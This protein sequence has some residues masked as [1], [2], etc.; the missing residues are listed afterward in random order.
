MTDQ[1]LSI[2]EVL[3]LLTAWWLERPVWVAVSGSILG[4]I[5]AVVGRFERRSR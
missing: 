4:G 5:I 3:T 1:H 2:G